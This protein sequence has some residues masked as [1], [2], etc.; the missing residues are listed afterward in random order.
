M[1]VGRRVGVKSKLN[2]TQYVKLLLL[3]CSFLKFIFSGC[4]IKTQINFDWIRGVDLGVARY[5]TDS[6]PSPPVLASQASQPRQSRS[7]LPQT[8]PEKTTMK[9]SLQGTLG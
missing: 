9:G 5:G 3:C 2:I 4:N 6:M 1:I 8:A 7:S